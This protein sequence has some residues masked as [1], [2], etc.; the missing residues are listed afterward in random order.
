[1]TPRYSSELSRALLKS[2]LEC[3]WLDHGEMMLEARFDH[4]RDA[5][6]GVPRDGFLAVVHKG[7]PNYRQVSLT[8]QLVQCG[9]DTWR[10]L[11]W[12]NYYGIGV[13]TDSRLSGPV[14]E[15]P[16]GLVTILP[17]TTSDLP[18]A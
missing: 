8:Y 4:I 11:T 12:T 10:M 5:V 16:A 1:M 17:F 9:D 18:R 14:Q 13:G 3:A 15:P 2:A 7:D 6:L